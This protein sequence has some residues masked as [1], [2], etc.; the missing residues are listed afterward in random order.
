MDSFIK[1]IFDGKGD[2]DEEV[3]LQFQKFSRGEF[4]GRAMIRAKN[5]KGKYTIATTSEYAKDLV[6]SLAEKLGEGKTQVTGALISALDLEGFDYKEKKSAL[7]VRK[8]II[9]SEMSGNELIDLCNKIQKAFF[10]LSFKVGESELKVQPKSPKS[11]KGASS[12]KKGG[13]K[14]K[15]NFCKLKTSDEN[16]IGNLIF[17][18]EAKNFKDVEIKHLFI[19]E[20]IIMP[21]EEELSEK[22]VEK[23]DFAKIRE[24][25]KRKGK[26]I[27][28]L[29]VDGKKVKKELEFVV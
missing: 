8:Y 23:N 29:D 10:G 11:A 14:A 15:I 4:S 26:I 28:E 22:G 6:M 13:E 12:Q 16:I 1:K 27:K 20:Q 3:H 21:T 24:L 19:I 5:S 18:E 7:G 25:A 17:D 9:D 2:V